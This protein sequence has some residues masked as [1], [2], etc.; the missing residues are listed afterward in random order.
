MKSQRCWEK[1]SKQTI[2]ALFYLLVQLIRVSLPLPNGRSL[3]R[4]P[5]L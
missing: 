2:K 1:C 3:P 5:Q 4:N